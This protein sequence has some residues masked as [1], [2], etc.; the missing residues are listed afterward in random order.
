[1]SVRFLSRSAGVL[2]LLEA[3]YAVEL[4]ADRWLSGILDASSRTLDLGAG[5]AALMYDASEADVRVTSH[6][7]RGLSRG[8]AEAGPRAHSDPFLSKAIATVYRSALSGSVS[9]L[10]A[11]QGLLT[12]TCELTR[13]RLDDQWVINGCD[14]AGLGCA[15]LL[16]AKHRVRMSARALDMAER[17]AVHLA[18]A[19]RLHRRIALGA[20]DVEAVFKPNG[21]VDHLEPIAQPSAARE[22]LSAAVQQ[23]SS[24]RAAVDRQPLLTTMRAWRGRIAGRWTLDAGRN[25][26]AVRC[27]LRSGAGEYTRGRR[28]FGF[29]FTRT[30]GVYAGSRRS[31]EQSDR[32][33]VGY[34]AL[35]RTR[36]VVPRGSQTRRANAGTTRSPSTRDFARL[37]AWPAVVS[38]QEI[39]HGEHTSLRFGLPVYIATELPPISSPLASACGCARASIRSQSIH[40]A[41]AT[42]STAHLMTRSGELSCVCSTRQADF[43]TR[44]SSRSSNGVHIHKE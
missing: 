43:H 40:A 3:I 2:D 5:V 30:R 38:G 27:A 13:L 18:T 10:F 37:R 8:V 23:R 12:L 14:P 20:G 39:T 28:T 36:V 4:S 24:A 25:V 7:G 32:V 9:D 17:V 35:D 26:R 21:R 31:L 29:I 41:V 1:V 33:R 6:G 16:P 15:I 34:L 11:G 44:C 42:V 22:S 19:H